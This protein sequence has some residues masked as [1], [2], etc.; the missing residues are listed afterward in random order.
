M[1]NYKDLEIYRLAYSLAL[2]VH[3]LTM[4]L[5]RYEMLGG[6]INKFIQYVEENWRV[7]T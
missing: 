1:K 3:K 5:P 2:E 4:N 6:K 7:R